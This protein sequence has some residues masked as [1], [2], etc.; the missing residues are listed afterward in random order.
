[1]KASGATAKRRADGRYE[2]SFVVEAR[3]LYAD[4]QGR[5]TEA[6]L[7][8]PLDIGAFTAKP[9]DR[10]FTARSVE[11]FERRQVHSGRHTVTLVVDAAPSWV[12]VDP[13]NKRIDRNSEG[14]LTR[15]GG[16]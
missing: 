2:V 9:G 3:K 12:G 13:Y 16:G 5:E 8:E 6:P 7:D 4:G 11:L 15:I 14:N 1:M 10:D